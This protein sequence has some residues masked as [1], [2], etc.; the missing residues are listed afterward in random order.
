MD[1]GAGGADTPAALAVQA[2]WVGPG[3]D[4]GDRG[5]GRVTT[6]PAACAGA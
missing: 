5:A 3:E 4:P 6:G 1:A 2:A